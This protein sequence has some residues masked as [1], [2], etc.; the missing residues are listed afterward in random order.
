L[1]KRVPLGLK[2]SFNGKWSQAVP[3]RDAGAEFHTEMFNSEE[4]IFPKSLYGRLSWTLG[5]YQF[6]VLEVNGQS[7]Y[8]SLFDKNLLISFIF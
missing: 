6:D 5:P 8:Q 3:D 2:Y 7:T 1:A 4:S